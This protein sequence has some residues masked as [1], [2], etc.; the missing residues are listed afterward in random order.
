MQVGVHNNLLAEVRSQ[1]SVGVND[2]IIC[3]KGRFAQDLVNNA[4]A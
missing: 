2:G 3:V 1:D 4:T